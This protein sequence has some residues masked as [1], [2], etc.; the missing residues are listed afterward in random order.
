[1]GGLR[2]GW[3][4][5]YRFLSDD[6]W[7]GSGDLALREPPTEFCLLLAQPGPQRVKVVPGDLV[8][9]VRMVSDICLVEIYRNIVT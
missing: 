8:F 6:S 2:A 7:T 4:L 1:M 5:G 9:L 3:V